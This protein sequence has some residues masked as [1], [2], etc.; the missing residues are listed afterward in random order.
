MSFPPCITFCG[1]VDVGLSY[2]RCLDYTYPWDGSFSISIRILFQMLDTLGQGMNVL[3]I[4]TTQK[5][6]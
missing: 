1:R 2:Q 3:R 5:Q 6:L 4:S